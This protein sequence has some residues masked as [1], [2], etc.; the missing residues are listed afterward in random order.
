MR[1]TET[2]QYPSKVFSDSLLIA[3]LD[4]REFQIRAK[5]LNNDLIGFEVSGER[6][7]EAI[8]D[9]YSNPKIPLLN[10]CASYK[11]IRSMIFNLKGGAR[12]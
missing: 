11:K 8:Q 9:F 12:R 3:Y 1:K 4:Y 6:L 2:G 10:F 5:P 7:D